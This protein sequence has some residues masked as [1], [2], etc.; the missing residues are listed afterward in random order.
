MWASR[1]IYTKLQ[2]G[3]LG[4]SAMRFI[5]LDPQM[6]DLAY[7]AGACHLPKKEKKEIPESHLPLDEF[8][9][10]SVDELYTRWMNAICGRNIGQ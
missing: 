4:S 9:H 6:T 3:V 7:L 10:L 1:T 8:E 5:N 2:R